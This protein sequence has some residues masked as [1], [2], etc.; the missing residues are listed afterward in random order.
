MEYHWVDRFLI[1]ITKIKMKTKPLSPKHGGY[2]RFKFKSSDI[3]VSNTSEN[4]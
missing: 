2:R 3:M 4:G 1:E